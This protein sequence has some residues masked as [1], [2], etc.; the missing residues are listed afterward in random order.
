MEQQVESTAQSSLSEG[1]ANGVAPRS[2]PPIDGHCLWVALHRSGWQDGEQGVIEA[3]IAHLD[4]HIPDDVRW[5]VEFGAGDGTS[6]PLTC[7]NVASAPNWRALLIDADPNCIRRLKRIV[8]DRAVVVH[9]SVSPKAD[10][11]G[12]DAMMAAAKCPPNPAVMV[13]DVD[14]IDYHIVATMASRPVVLCVET[15]DT[16][17]PKQS[18]EPW[19]PPVEECGK[20]IEDGFDTQVQAN[21]AAFD[22]LLGERGYSLVYRTRYNS[23]YVRGDMVPKLRKRKLN[24]GCGDKNMPGYDPVDIRTNGI[25]VR[26]LPYPD[27]SQDE[28]Y[29][30]HTLEH[31]DCLESQHALAEWVRVLKPGGVLK[32]AVPDLMKIAQELSKPDLASEEVTDQ[33]AMLYGSQNYP[34]NYHKWGYTEASLRRVM[35]WAGLGGIRPFKPFMPG[36]CSNNPVSLNLEGVKRWWP[37]ID[38]PRIALVLSQPRFTFSGHEQSLIELARDLAMSGTVGS[39]D[40]QMSHGAFWDRDMTIATRVAIERFDPDI[41]LYSDYDSMFKPKDV[42]KLLEAM[43]NDPQMAA[44]GSVQISRHHDKPLVMDPQIDYSGEITRVRFQ[45]FGLTLIRR[46]VFDELGK[47]WFWSVPGKNEKGEWDWDAWARSDADITF[48]RGM[49]MMGFRVF[50]HNGVCIGHFIEA[51]KLPRDTETGVQIIPM[52]RFLQQGL[53]ADAKFNQDCYRPKPKEEKK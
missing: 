34:E 40:V 45:H 39:F 21:G 29:A 13:V 8:T 52:R 17:S 47:P 18:D 6:L 44:I 31:L 20:L 9:A 49:D 16:A 1:P 3:I 36:D 35:Y 24:L 53:P 14:S 32:I 23:I 27:C 46:E 15:L 28:V 43:Q 2:G 50:Q 22:V 10:F 33:L 4:P 38:K 30:S 48:W 51:V 12:I 19:I 37:K 5:C 26:K 41:L 7:A 42:L 11:G 25:D